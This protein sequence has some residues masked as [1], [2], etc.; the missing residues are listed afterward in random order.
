MPVFSTLADY[1]AGIIRGF[2]HDDPTP[3]KVFPLADRIDAINEAR[4]EI[5]EELL[6]VIKSAAS[7]TATVIG[8]GAYTLA[9]TDNIMLVDAVECNGDLLQKR[10]LLDDRLWS[11]ISNDSADR[12]APL[13]WWTDRST[14]TIYLFPKPDAANPL[15]IRGY[16]IPDPL[17]QGSTAELVAN[18]TFDSDVASW[19]VTDG[20]I[21]SVG[22]ECRI[23]SDGVAETRMHQTVTGLTVGTR[24]S[25]SAYIAKGTADSIRVKVGNTGENS[26]EYG[27]SGAQTGA[28]S[29]LYTYE[30]T[31][32]TTTMTMTFVLANAGLGTVYSTVDTASLVVAGSTVDVESAI[33]VPY[34]RM[35]AY[36]TLWKGFER[37]G[38]TDGLQR[39]Q[40]YQSLYSA[41][42][43][44]AKKRNKKSVWH[45][46]RP[47]IRFAGFGLRDVYGT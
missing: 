32:T 35:V 1:L 3:H 23:D 28:T 6:C 21:S 40:Y 4:E 27:D 2:P 13:Y 34:R 37:D 45:G 16:G 14:Q 43:T 8:Q 18:G 5:A 33:P 19:S 30:F 10:E 24:Y 12:G 47:K 25:A 9:S 44:R 26:S 38:I 29:T 41:E 46:A 7:I 15:T 42:M 31:A 20:A 36:Y 11:Q 39:A 22:A 17:Q